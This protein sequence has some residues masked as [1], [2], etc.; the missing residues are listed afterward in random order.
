MRTPRFPLR[1]AAVIMAAVSLLFSAR[2][3]DSIDWDHARDLY[4]RSQRGEPLSPEDQSYLDRAKQAHAAM[5]AARNQDGRQPVNASPASTET[6][7]VPLTDL[8]TKYK[9]DDGG[10]YGAGLNTPPPEL[11]ATA[12]TETAKIQPLDADGK[13]SPD[14]KIVLLSIGMSNTT[15]EFSRFALLAQADQDKSPRLVIVDGAQGGQTADRIAT[16]TAP[17]WTVIGQR[18]KAAG[19]TPAQVQVIWLKEANANPKAGFPDEAQHLKNSLVEDMAIAK[20]DYPN[21]RIA[22]LSSRIYAGYANTFLNPEPY[23]YEGAFAVRW[24]IQDQLKSG[25]KPTN[26]A[27]KPGGQLPLMLWG[28]Y[29]WAD[30]LKGRKAGDLVWK[31]EDFGPDGT[32]PSELGRQKV[33]IILLDF[34]KTDPDARTWFVKK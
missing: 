30:G 21:L 25:S 9:G 34:F 27:A 20:K 18:L 7:L 4:Q 11:A 29:L 6:G 31:R 33:A 17:F 16:D 24:A 13:P 5:E 3:A 2:G 19:V 10:L 22:Y 23:A 12:K 8:T 28:P 1:A 32:H 26:D 14:G 15:M